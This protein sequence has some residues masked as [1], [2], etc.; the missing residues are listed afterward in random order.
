[1]R[2]GPR[3][4]TARFA[5]AL[6][7]EL[8]RARSAAH[9]R[10]S[11]GPACCPAQR[12]PQEARPPCT[13]TAGSVPSDA[14]MLRAPSPED[15]R[16]RSR[17]ATWPL[18]PSF[19]PSTG[20]GAGPSA[21]TAPSAAPPHAPRPPLQASRLP[22]PLRT[23][24]ATVPRR[25]Q[26]FLL[27]AQ[28]PASRPHWT[29][30]QAR[31]CTCRHPHAGPRGPGLLPALP[32]AAPLS[33]RP[34]PCR[35]PGGVGFLP[36][37]GSLRQPCKSPADPAPAHLVSISSCPSIVWA[38]MCQALGDSGQGHLAGPQW[39]VH[40]R[41]KWWLQGV[42]VCGGSWGRTFTICASGNCVLGFR[43]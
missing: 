2:Q 4:L 20:L 12:L 35:A 19:P 33:S 29:P 9:S 40:E 1:M 14:S 16:T 38:P 27:G 6:P 21:A 17:R 28:S 22:G 23:L 15:S 5:L 37:G 36:G 39:T 13:L 7:R 11:G 26:A 8:W 10:W 32:S 34:F 41:R 3:N 42:C 31:H 25:G 43:R 30:R 24:P 18:P